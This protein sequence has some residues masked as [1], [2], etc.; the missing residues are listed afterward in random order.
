[1][2]I[3]RPTVADLESAHK[4]YKIAIADAFKHEGLEDLVTEIE[5]EV[6]YKMTMIR[7]SLFNPQSKYRFL[8]AKQDDLVVASISF[9][10]CGKETTTCTEGALDHVGELGSLY[11]LPTYQ[12]HGLGSDMISSMLLC[13]QAEGA[14]QFCCDSGYQRAQKRW[15]NKFGAP[16]HIAKDFWGPGY[17]HYIWLVDIASQV[18]LELE[19]ASPWRMDESLQ[20]TLKSD[21]TLG[22]HAHP[23]NIS[24]DRTV[25]HETPEEMATR[26]SILTLNGKDLGVLYLEEDETGPT[27]FFDWMPNPIGARMEGVLIRTMPALLGLKMNLTM[28]SAAL[29]D[30]YQ[31]MGFQR[32][33]YV[34]Y[35]GTCDLETLEIS[36][37]FGKFQSAA[38]Q[39]PVKYAIVNAHTALTGLLPEDV[40]AINYQIANLIGYATGD[41]VSLERYQNLLEDPKYA[42]AKPLLV[43]DW[44]QAD[45]E[46][47]KRPFVLAYALFWCDLETHTAVLEP[48]ACHIN[49][50]R[51]GLTK[52]LLTHGLADLKAHGYQKVFV[53]TSQNNKASQALYASVGFIRQDWL[54]TY[55]AVDFSL[56]DAVDTIVF[57]LYGTLLDIHT[58]ESDPSLWRRL[59][60]AFAAKGAHYEPQALQKAYEE[61]VHLAIAREQARYLVLT[62]ETITESQI[63]IDL[64]EVFKMLFVQKGIDSEAVDAR[65]LQEVATIFRLL[66]LDYVKPYPHAI[67]LLKILK[68]KG[69]RIVLLS[70][71]QACFTKD[72]LMATG[73]EG[74][75]DSVYLSSDYQLCKPH[76][77]YF[78]MML[79]K[80]GLQASQCLFI[81]NDHRTDIAGAN[82]VG[83]PSLYMHTNC[84]AETVPG[85]IA[86]LW[87]VDSG[88]LATVAQLTSHLKSSK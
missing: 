16:Y 41:P 57:D 51:Q 20:A 26:L 21:K 48:V 65:G 42:A 8:V 7:D 4:L 50:R 11:V 72:E 13:M 1:M 19:P 81:G 85:P 74:Y 39:A 79:E 61:Q 46:M 33:D 17:D 77:G 66:S 64:L 29:E 43:L 63:D 67:D 52:Q 18:K 87:R 37:E 31:D 78:E 75:F 83:M 3:V 40:E 53:G 27:G 76:K 55:K 38:G 25:C 58:D 62:G 54:Y 22:Y 68:A 45:S 86:A 23:G 70:N 6:A 5:E 84:S 44:Q 10:P 60:Y 15:L 24:F 49:H 14:T 59:A 9:G 35:C 80:E 88:N 73:I 32:G 34:R 56:L 36:E 2:L 30:L 71:A 69:L 82:T 28:A 47:T 12:G